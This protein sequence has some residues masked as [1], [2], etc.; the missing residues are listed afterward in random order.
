MPRHSL[1]QKAAIFSAL[2]DETRLGI[3]H[4]LVAKNDLSISELSEGE[5]I[6]RQAVT[7]HL[8]VLEEVGVVKCAREGRES[9]YSLNTIPLQEVME[10]LSSVDKKWEQRL[11]RLKIFSENTD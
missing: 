3:V 4:K 5:V 8:R 7:K 2:G 9:R 11:L 6:T 1:G 10:L